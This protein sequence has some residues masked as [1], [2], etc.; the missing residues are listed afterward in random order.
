MT[1]P[2]SPSASGA[3]LSALRAGDLATAQRL[4]A[5]GARL[6]A[7]RAQPLALV[8]PARQ[9]VEVQQLE[10]RVGRGVRGFPRAP[11]ARG[12]N[13]EGF[14]DGVPWKSHAR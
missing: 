4:A 6:D 8:A 5:R 12:S 3:L 2:A 7:H 9:A 13:P 11:R 10:R 14:L 1:S